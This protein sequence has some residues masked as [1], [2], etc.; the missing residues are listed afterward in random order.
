MY[1]KAEIFNLALNAL[2]LQRQI[3][4]AD[5]DQTPEAKML[6]KMWEPALKQTINDLDLD[7][8]SAQFNLELYKED[9][10]ELWLFA[11]HRPQN[12]ASI[13]R[14]QST[15]KQDNRYTKIPLATGILDGRPVIYTNVYQA[16]LD[17]IPTDVPLSAF[18][19]SDGLALA[20]K[21]AYLSRSL[22]VGKGAKELTQEILQNYLI[23][24]AEAQEH[25]RMENMNFEEDRVISEFVADRLS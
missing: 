18:A 15:V 5:E 6:R 1:T 20:H 9:P 3:V 22:I 14:I 23:H 8:H 24:K 12:C 13:R 25:D 10:N 21:L 16:V 2:L 11:Y 19:A 7:R 17:Y 4:D